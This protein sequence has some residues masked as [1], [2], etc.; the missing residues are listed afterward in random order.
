MKQL[1]VVVTS[2]FAVALA[3]IPILAAAFSAD[4]GSN[5]VTAA[6]EATREAREC[7]SIRSD[8]DQVIIETIEPAPG[9]QLR[10][11]TKVQVVASVEYVLDS[12][13]E[14]TLNIGVG[15]SIRTEGATNDRGFRITRGR[16]EATVSAEIEVPTDVS[17]PY[18]SVYMHPLFGDVKAAGYSCWN[19]LD[20]DEKRYRA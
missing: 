6:V 15:N 16:G 17:R 13:E 11:G 9:S 20:T 7:Y 18:I 2:L 10:P 5:E 19:P 14:A 8:K 3:V 12:H 1:A 4:A